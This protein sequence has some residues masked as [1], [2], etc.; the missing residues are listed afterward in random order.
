MSELPPAE[1]S[2]FPLPPPPLLV[3]LVLD[4]T[5]LELLLLALPPLIAALYD[6]APV[7][8]VWPPRPN[9]TLRKKEKE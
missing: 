3:L 5:V 8:E 4:D 2:E 7:M 1:D 9:N 6:A